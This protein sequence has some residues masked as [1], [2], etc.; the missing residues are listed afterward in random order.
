MDIDLI[1]DQAKYIHFIKNKI[2]DTGEITLTATDVDALDKITQTLTSFK[3]FLLSDYVDKA[4][5]NTR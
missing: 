4:R 5:C 1:R 3:L 2:C